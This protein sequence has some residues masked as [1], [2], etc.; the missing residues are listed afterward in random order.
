MLFPTMQS[1]AGDTPE[2]C[3][4]DAPLSAHQPQ[5][6]VPD[7]S[8]CEVSALVFH[9]LMVVAHKESHQVVPSR[10][11]EG[12]G[13]VHLKAGLSHASAHPEK[14]T[15]VNHWTQLCNVALFQNV[16]SF[17]MLLISLGYLSCC[18]FFINSSFAFSM[19]SGV[20]AFLQVCHP[21]HVSSL[22]F[23]LKHCYV[24]QDCKCSSTEVSVP[25]LGC[26][27]SV[28]STVA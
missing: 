22:S 26:V 12:I 8:L 25:K 24:N 14:S 6:S 7:G 10:D 21:L 1:P 9:L 3:A 5:S 16:F 13:A 23:C 19:F 2:Q 20:I 15:A 28:T 17:C 4:S 11:D 18:M 27:V